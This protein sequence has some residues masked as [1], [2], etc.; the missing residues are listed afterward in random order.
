[1]ILKD[2]AYEYGHINFKDLSMLHTNNLVNGLPQIKNPQ[3]VCEKCLV[4]KQPRSAF[5][6]YVP[7][8]ASDLL[9]IIYSDVCGPF[10]VN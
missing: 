10:E 9:N 1:M 3:V 8:R 4:S 5:G 7:S 6:S 2:L